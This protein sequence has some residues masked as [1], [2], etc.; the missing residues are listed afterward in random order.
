MLDTAGRIQDEL[1]AIEK[2]IA[3]GQDRKPADIRRKCRKLPLTLPMR[4]PIWEA[5][6]CVAINPV[7]KAWRARLTG[8]SAQQRR[9][10][11]SPALPCADTRSEAAHRAGMRTQFAF[12]SVF[13]SASENQI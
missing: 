4:F 11:F 8:W 10:S 13:F 3:P 9:S 12:Q 5:V 7:P 6:A 2:T 1:D